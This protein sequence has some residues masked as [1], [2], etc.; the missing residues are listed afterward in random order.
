MGYKFHDVALDTWA[1]HNGI[2]MSMV[3]RALFTF[4]EEVRSYFGRNLPNRYPKAT[5]QDPG[6]WYTLGAQEVRR[7]RYNE[8]DDLLR[9]TGRIE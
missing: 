1:E 7:K 9:A 6:P 8:Q 2:K 5:I 4:R 3:S